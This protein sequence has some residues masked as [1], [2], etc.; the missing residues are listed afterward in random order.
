MML[1]HFGSAIFSFGAETETGERVGDW[2]SNLGREREGR[3]PYPSHLRKFINAIGSSAI[4]LERGYRTYKTKG[5]KIL[6][7]NAA[8]NP[9]DPAD[10]QEMRRLMAEFNGSLQV[11][12]NSNIQI[13]NDPQFNELSAGERNKLAQQLTKSTLALINIYRYTNE[14][15]DKYSKR[16]PPK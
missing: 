8:G 15:F 2:W 10:V 13:R 16:L 5:D 11:I 9:V 3:A 4:D 14:F 1:W 6:T 7:A 12:N